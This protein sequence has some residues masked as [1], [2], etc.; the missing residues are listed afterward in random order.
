MRGVRRVVF[1]RKV[2]ERRRSRRKSVAAAVRDGF[3]Y[4]RAA[5]G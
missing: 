5:K 3:F 4:A 1:A 2:A